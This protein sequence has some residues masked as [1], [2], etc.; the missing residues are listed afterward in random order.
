MAQTI[1]KQAV[2]DSFSKAASHYDQ[3]AQLQRDIG[4]QL[5]SQVNASSANTVVDL[6]CGTGYFSEKLDVQFP[7]SELTCFDL[8]P[9]M[10]NQTRQRELKNVHFQQ[11]DIDQLPFD[12]NSVDLIY[13]NLVIQWSDDFCECLKQIKNSLKVGAKAYLSTLL[14]GTLDEL[15]QAWKSVDDNPHTNRFLSLTDIENCLKQSGFSKT[16]L[17]KET[18]TLA[19]KNVLEVM[20]ALKG[21]GAN[22]VHDHQATKLTG[23]RLVKQLEMGYLPFKNEQGLLNLTYQVCYIEITK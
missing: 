13:S 11:G 23:K 19:Y 3:F 14:I 8:S 9:A 6:G 5:L 12:E 16:Q 18:R 17:K 1:D 4:E 7:H 21:I 10:L 2:A 22:H 20:R 15:T